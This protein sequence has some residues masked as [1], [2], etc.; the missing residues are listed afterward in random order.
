ME[1]QSGRKLLT[2][3]SHA[4]VAE[5]NHHLPT[6]RRPLHRLTIT[7]TPTPVDVAIIIPKITAFL[8]FLAGSTPSL[9]LWMHLHGQATWSS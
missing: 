8:R 3:P 1:L 6:R 9:S 5:H 2:A 4:P 7:P